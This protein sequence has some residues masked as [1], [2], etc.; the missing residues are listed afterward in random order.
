M[1]GTKIFFFT[2]FAAA[3]LFSACRNAPYDPGTAG[4][5]SGGSIPVDS[6]KATGSGVSGKNPGTP[7]SSDTASKN[8][9]ATDTAKKKK[10]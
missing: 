3:V 5:S 6:L 2:F 1:R 7:Y 8:Y 4:G 10:Q 9:I